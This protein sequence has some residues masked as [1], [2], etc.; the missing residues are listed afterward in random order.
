MN[1]SSFLYF[2]AVIFCSLNAYGFDKNRPVL[3]KAFSTRLT[4]P[5]N[6]FLASYPPVST[7]RNDS[8]VE[9]VAIFSLSLLL[10]TICPKP[11]EAVI[12]V[13][14]SYKNFVNV[15]K[16]LLL[17]RNPNEIRTKI[18][19]LLTAILPNFVKIFFRKQYSND[20]KLVSELSVQWFG[21]GFLTW[22]VGPVEPKLSQITLTDGSIQIWNSTVKLTECRYLAESGC[23]A[24]CTQ[25][26]K[27]PTQ[28][29]FSEQLGVPLYMKPNF[30]DYSCELMFGVPA[31]PDAEDEAYLEPCY[32]ACLKSNSPPPS[33]TC[34]KVLV[35]L[36]SS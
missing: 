27:R 19:N 8:A 21:F 13:G 1:F 3:R 12:N 33:T 20:P 29:F 25:L 15:S 31:P 17:E 32:V 24:A 23:K 10:C 36:K 11:F 2:L 7:L 9:K 34:D 6:N 18:V 4:P 28:A 5:A 16:L 35:R 26:C 30:T 22:L 14:T